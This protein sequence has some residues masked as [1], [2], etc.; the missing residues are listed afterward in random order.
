MMVNTVRGEN[1]QKCFELYITITI[2]LVN[3]KITGCVTSKGANLLWLQSK[4]HIL[5]LLCYPGAN[6]KSVIVVPS[7]WFH[8]KYQPITHFI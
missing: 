3:E 1:S 2:H 6:D 8:L 7:L 4:L 5:L